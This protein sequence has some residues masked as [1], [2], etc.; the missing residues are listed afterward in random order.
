MKM[1]LT[2]I[3]A[4]CL[5]ASCPAPQRDNKNRSNAF[6]DGCPEAAVDAVFVSEKGDDSKQNCGSEAD[7]CKTIA[8]GIELLG[9]GPGDKSV[10]IVD[11]AEIPYGFQFLKDFSL[12]IAAASKQGAGKTL[13]FE[14]DGIVAKGKSHMVNEKTLTLEHL[15]FNLIPFK[16]DKLSKEAEASSAVILSRGVGGA[17]TIR[18][19]GICFQ[20]WTDEYAPFSI[21]RITE[22]KLSIDGFHWGYLGYYYLSSAAILHISEDVAVQK[23]KSLQM[24]HAKLEK[25]CA[26]EL[27]SSFTLEGSHFGSVERANAGPAL[28]EAKSGAD[29]KVAITISECKISSMQSQKSENGGCIYFEMM[30]PESELNIVDTIFDWGRAVRG[31]G[32]MIGAMKGKVKLENVEFR[33]CEAA[34]DGGGL[35]IRDL[36]QM[37]GFECRNGT[38]RGCKAK[39][40]GGMAIHLGEE[41]RL[42]DEILFKN[43]FFSDNSAG[44]CGNDLALCS[45]GDV[46]MSRTPFDADSFSVTKDHRVGAIKKDGAIVFY[47]DWLRFDTLDIDVDGENGEDS[48]E[49]GRRGKMA[50]KTMKQ[51]LLN[52]L[53]G[54]AFTVYAAEDGNKYDAEPIMIEERSAKVANRKDNVIS[55]T[56]VLDEAK[57]HPGEGLFNVRQN[58]NFGLYRADVQ[59]DTTRQSGRDNGLFVC[60]GDRAC[61]DIYRV[62]ISCTDSQQILNCVLIECKMGTLYMN[63]VFISHFTSS[64]ALVLVE[65]GEYVDL[66][67]L[68][69]DTVSTM[70]TAQSIVTI[71]AGCRQL[72]F[73]DGKFS[74]CRSTEHR[75]GGVLHLEIGNGNYYSFYGAEFKNCSCKGAQMTSDGQGLMLNEESKGGAMFIRVG[76]EITGAVNLRLNGMRFSECWADRGELVYLSF[77]SGRK[78]IKEELFEFEMEEIYGKANLMLLEERKGGEANVVD[79]LSDEANRLP[80]HSQNIYV[81]GAKASDDKVCGA[82]ERPCDLL[83]TAIEHGI[84]VKVMTM[85]VIGRV[86]VNEP[87]LIDEFVTLTSASVPSSEWEQ[88]SGTTWKMLSGAEKNRGILR[89]GANMKA[90]ESTAVFY[91]DNCYLKFEHID[92]EYPDAVEGGCAGCDLPWYTGLKG[93]NVKGGEGRALPYRLIVFGHRWETF[94][95]LVIYGRNGNITSSKQH[96]EWKDGK[97][98]EEKRSSVLRLEEPFASRDGMNGVGEEESQLCLWDCGL[99]CLQE[100]SFVEMEDSRF[101]DIGEGAIYGTQSCLSLNN[102]S[103]VNNH[104]I[105]KDWEKFASL[106]NNIRFLEKEREK[107]LFINSLAAGS[108]GLEGRPFGMLVEVEVGGRAAE[109]MDSYFFSPV[110][111]NATMIKKA[112]ETAEQ[113][114]GGKIESD[115]GARAV[116]QGCY[117]FPCGLTVEASKKRVGGRKEW[118]E[119]PVSEYVNETEMRVEIPSSLL[120]G[121]EYTSLVCRL[122]YPSGISEGEKRST[123]YITLAK[124]K[125]EDPKKLTTAQLVA[126]IVSV[127]VCSVAAVVGVVIVAC[128]VRKRKRRQYKRIADEKN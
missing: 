39:T 123:E 48:A 25:E 106:R 63:E 20:K 26:L 6:S 52:C 73:N 85:H 21:L 78:Q 114:K 23:L 82:K 70:S 95:Q 107:P 89:I 88:G 125:K 7:P 94:T 101:V 109:N 59:V 13:D 8:K 81:G 15:M 113:G 4:N 74:N 79:L 124:Q 51:A 76:D 116:I 5:F 47:E 53:A 96:K 93:E 103:F 56:T 55:I 77:P 126:V 19:V 36:T 68:S 115:E 10:K 128:V 40:G 17:L 16:T 3:L 117:L 111:K 50:C 1:F 9:E 46:E 27:R 18:H 58:A 72:S 42:I 32:A 2:L 97:E 38:F 122:R 34:A 22:G 90:E 45:E 75:L 11:S 99:V 86:F 108:D 33:S 69:M 44:Q 119:C 92:M 104:P 24:D 65:A 64:F 12:G 30:H 54:R 121:D 112:K 87:F 28:L 61:A 83:S 67:R 62:N 120:D 49:C 41:T 31:G 80:Y 35:V 100:E 84:H 127:S 105:G 98:G 110:L 14:L 60:D 91:M 66:I 43:C 118:I 37:A 102:C 57:A 71:L 29:K